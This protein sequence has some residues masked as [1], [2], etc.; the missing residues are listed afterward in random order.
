MATT[1]NL[2]TSL[3]PFTAY[4][5]DRRFGPYLE[6]LLLNGGRLND[7]LR[8]AVTAPLEQGVKPV[9]INSYPT[10]VRAYLKRLHSE[11]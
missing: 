4:V 7:R 11:G 9:S 3:P 10:C 2:I 5:D 1:I 8:A 6:P